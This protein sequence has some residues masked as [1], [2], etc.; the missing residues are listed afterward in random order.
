[1]TIKDLNLWHRLDDLESVVRLLSERISKEV[2][3]LKEGKLG[4]ELQKYVKVT[5]LIV[6]DQK[7]LQ[8][9]ELANAFN[10]LKLVVLTVELLH[11]DVWRDIVQVL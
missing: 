5:Q 6:A 7:D 2:Q 10:I 11:S 1:M 4:Q 8:E 3:L 9:F